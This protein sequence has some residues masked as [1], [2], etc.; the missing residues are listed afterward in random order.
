MASD[1]SRYERDEPD[2]SNWERSLYDEVSREEPWEIVEEFSELRR[3]SPSDDE[4]EAAE[5]LEE[6]FNKYDVPYERYNPEFWLSVPKQAAI[7]TGDK[8]FSGSE[9]QWREERPSVKALAFSGSTTVSG[10]V[11]HLELPE[12]ESSQDVLE[13][14]SL[15]TEGVDLEG[16]IV[17]IDEMIASKQFF[18][19]IEEA[20]AAALVSIHPHPEEPQITTAMPIWGAIP[21][22]DQRD[23]LPEMVNVTV[24]KTVGNRLLELL[25]ENDGLELEVS[26]DV[27]EG[28]WECPL[29][30]G[31]IPG[32]AAPENDDFVLLHGHL[33][34]WYYG[35]TD[36][37]T[38]NAGMLECARILNE[39]R[40]RLKRDLWIA[41]WPA[42]EGG[43]Y[44]G[45]TWFADEFANDLIEDCVAHINFDSPGVKDATEF[46]MTFWHQEAHDLCLSTIE[47][48]TGKDAREARPPRAG[49]YSF[50]NLGVSG[51]MLLSSGIPEEIK[52][53]R[54]YY[55]VG[56]S[57][58]NSEAWHHTTDTLDKADPDVLK[59]DIRVHLI[60]LARALTRDVLPLDYR[61][62]I[63]RHQRII[64]EYDEEANAFD[65]TPVRE[66][67]DT[68]QESVDTFYEKVNDGQIGEAK[69][70][71]AMKRL[72]RHLVR[73]N[74]TER[75]T[76]EQDPAMHRQ[77]YPRLE[78]ATK[79]HELTGN[80]YRFRERNLRRAVNYVVHELREARRELPV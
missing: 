61:R 2:L 5:R 39:H 77:P 24:S 17:L 70:N 53:E 52:D 4:K 56:G 60:L 46:N 44:G 15:D 59:R 48:V 31:K 38:G 34:S 54:G 49:D 63:Q 76:F 69:A 36:N 14:A 3:L 72:S 33:D 21:A 41:F 74:Y 18:K 9:E 6:R 12:T 25:E 47:D 57:G 40:D 80:D 26:A 1:Y 30:V 79:L 42:H 65:L 73:V 71:E 75:G 55:P 23:M 51:M 43:R 32:E 62:T 66:E 11:V 13:Q 22:D 16:K 37:A 8:E 29:V 35:V 45:S 50:Y 68:L 58:G 19:T 67:L 28:W 20:G 27:E 10:E 78:P 7:R 64:D